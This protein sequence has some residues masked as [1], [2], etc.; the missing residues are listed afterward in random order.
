MRLFFPDLVR[1]IDLNG[2]VK[3]VA[4]IK[5]AEAAPVA[6]EGALSAEESA[7]R[8]SAQPTTVPNDPDA[9]AALTEGERRIAERNPRA[10]EVAFQR[11]LARYPDQIRAWYGI[12]MVALIDRD[13]PRAKQVFGRLT[14]GEHAATQDP[15]VMA[16]SH[17]Y[18]ARIY[19]DEGQADLAKSEYQ[20][21]LSVSGGPDQARQAAQRGLSA[22]GSEKNAQRP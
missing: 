7:R 11:V 19:D 18:L 14:V 20:A 16:W 22:F 12:G 1:A 21:A 13:A 10:A 17:I 8:R 5:F 3:R 2:E 6:A 9:I 15:M 4:S